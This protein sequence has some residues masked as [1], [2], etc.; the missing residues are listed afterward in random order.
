MI[1]KFA[2]V[3]CL[4]VVLALIFVTILAGTTPVH[5]QQT[6][7]QQPPAQQ[8]PAQQ[9]PA[10][11]PSAQQPSDQS[12][13][14]Q[15]SVEESTSRRKVKVKDYK[16]WNFNVGGGASLTTGTTSEFVKGGGAVVAAGV[17][18]NASKYFGLRVDFQWDNLPLRSS[19]LHL[20]QAPGA[21]SQVYSIMLDPIIT[22][23]ATKVWSGYLV[24]GPA[25]LHRSG[26]IDSSTAVPGSACDVFWTW[27]GTCYN[28]SLPLNKNFLSTS[29][30]E[31]GY[32]FGGGVVRK[33]TPKIEF[34]AEYRYL[35]GKHNGLNTNVQPISIGLRF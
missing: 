16:N 29:Q 11:Q 15:A 26:K 10:Q 4:R 35:H 21:T 3:P 7:D 20:A 2:T 1:R 18:R 5:A 8:P 13:V 34:Y 32:N 17:A 19:A 9:P 24:I 33:I 25:F 22:I 27:W 6:P 12:G 30:N 23:P 28:G 31:F 14:Q